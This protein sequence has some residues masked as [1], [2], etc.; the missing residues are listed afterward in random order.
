[1]AAESVLQASGTKPLNTYINKRQAK[2]ADWVA[3]RPIFEVFA[4]DAG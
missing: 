2:V 1:M 3:L 4:K